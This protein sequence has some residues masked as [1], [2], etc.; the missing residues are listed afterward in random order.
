VAGAGA[1][2]SHRRGAGFYSSV[3]GPLPFAF[4]NTPAQSLF[5][6]E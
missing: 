5:I 4:G 6:Y 1:G 3:V 2:G